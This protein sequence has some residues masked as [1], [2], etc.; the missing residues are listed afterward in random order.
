MKETGNKCAV[1][2][3][4]IRVII[5]VLSK[6]MIFEHISEGRKSALHHMNIQGK[7]M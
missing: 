1:E 3:K 5:G 6:T 7:I 2:P 4:G